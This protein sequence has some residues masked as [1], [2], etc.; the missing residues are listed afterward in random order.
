LFSDEDVERIMN[1]RESMKERVKETTGEA[2]K[3]GAFGAPWLI[4]T[5]ADGKSE[6]FFGSDR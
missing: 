4:A 2:L 3:Q 6:A 1:G 5:R